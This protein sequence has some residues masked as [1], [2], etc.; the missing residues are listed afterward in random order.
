MSQAKPLT[1]NREQLSLQAA[2][3]RRS[4]ALWQ[5]AV[6]YLL[7]DRL[8][9]LAVTLLSFLTLLSFVGAPVAARLLDIDYTKTNTPN[10]FQPPNFAP[11]YETS[12]TSIGADGL[13]H[14]VSQMASVLPFYGETE[15]TGK[16]G[17]HILGT[18][19]VGRDQF[20]RLLYG[21][22]VSLLIAIITSILSLILG[23]ALGL[24]GGYFGGILDDVLVWFITTV[25][26]IPGIF[27]LIVTASLFGQD[28]RTLI[29]ILVFYGWLL[30]CRLVRGEVISLKQR[31]YI[32]AALAVG[33]PRLR[34]LAVHLLPNV[35][36]IAVV[37]LSIHAG[38]L[39]LIEAGLS[40]LGLGV[41]EPQPTWGNMLSKARSYFTRGQYLVYW[42]GIMITMTVLSLYLLGDG[43]RDALDPRTSRR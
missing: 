3:D 43:I 8:T 32:L 1:M 12:W 21:G 19:N 31:E 42:P 25:N 2:Q 28:P 7:R 14:H 17:G 11:I 5:D 23:V 36:Y 34:I 30:P 16:W 38:T 35:F 9:M 37:S 41:A 6:R 29:L 26:S 15:Y 20:V 24:L 13:Q 39:I 10:Q 18:D 22:Q 40:F 4:R 33:A 27:L